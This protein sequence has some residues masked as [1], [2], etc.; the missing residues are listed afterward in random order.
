MVRREL[1]ESP[2]GK[3]LVL[4]KELKLRQTVLKWIEHDSVV[5]GLI[6]AAFL[7]ALVKNT[8]IYLASL[9]MDSSWPMK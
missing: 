4:F 9:E 7:T 3:R 2:I 6:T 5:P 1:V 8:I